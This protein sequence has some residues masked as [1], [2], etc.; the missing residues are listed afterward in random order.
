MV[1]GGVIMSEAFGTAETLHEHCRV[2]IKCAD[3]SSS[4]NSLELQQGIMCISYINGFVD[5]RFVSLLEARA[6]PTE[7]CL[8]DHVSRLQTIRVF[9][10]YAND[11]PEHLHKPDYAVL[12]LA[13]AN[14][15]PCK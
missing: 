3:I 4:C 1:L 12:Y 8:P 6:K 15:F 7:I 9:I 2:A 11:H 14:A 10:K 13:F 5:G